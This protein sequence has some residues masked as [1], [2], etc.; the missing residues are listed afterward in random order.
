MWEY[1]LTNELFWLMAVHCV[2][3]N[4]G[5]WSYIQGS[6]RN[7]ENERK[8]NNL[9]WMLYS[10]YAVLGVCCT[11]CMLY[12]VYAVLG[13][14]CTWW[15]LYSLYAVFGVHCTRCMLYL[16]NA[17]LTVNSWSWDREIERDDLTLGSTMMV[18]LWM[19]KRA[20]GDEYENDVEDTR[21][22]EKS[23]VWHAWLGWEDLVLV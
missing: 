5:S 10:V 12:L 17:V 18:E 15:M 19:R 21:E 20:M 7:H 9:G 16:A 11:R 23:G 8:T 2:G 14:C 1:D 6:T 22:C 3:R 4:A 13:L